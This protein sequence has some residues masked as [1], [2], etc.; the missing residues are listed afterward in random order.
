MIH[1]ISFDIIKIS[2]LAYVNIVKHIDSIQP[3]FVIALTKENA[4][5][6]T[7]ILTDEKVN[8]FVEEIE[9]KENKT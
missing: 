9:E 6:V 1:K 3:G 8:F 5:V 7:Q 4:N 2:Q